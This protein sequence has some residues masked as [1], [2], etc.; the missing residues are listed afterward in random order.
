MLLLTIFSIYKNTHISGNISNNENESVFKHRVNL[1]L[2]SRKVLFS[3][4]LVFLISFCHIVALTLFKIARPDSSPNFMDTVKTINLTRLCK[5]ITNTVDFPII[6]T[7]NNKE[8]QNKK[9]VNSKAKVLS[10][11]IFRIY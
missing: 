5:Q 1:S 11:T 6:H 8:T 7:S 3:S 10:N 4:W 2:N 9:H